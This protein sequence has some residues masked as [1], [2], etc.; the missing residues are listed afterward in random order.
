MARIVRFYRGA[1]PGLPDASGYHDPVTNVFVE[2]TISLRKKRDVPETC[3][4]RRR[5]DSVSST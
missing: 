4:E 1:E 2:G 3:F 5:A